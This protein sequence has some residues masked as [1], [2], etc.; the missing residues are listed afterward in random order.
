M[1]M[2]HRPWSRK[3]FFSKQSNGW[4]KYVIIIT[5][6]LEETSTWL[7]P[8]HKKD[9]VNAYWIIIVTFSRKLLSFYTW[10]ILMNNG[11][12]AYNNKRREHHVASCLN[13]FLVSYSLMVAWPDIK[14]SILP[15]YGLD[16][17]LIFFQL[18]LCVNPKLHP[19]C[20][21]FFY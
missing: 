7:P 18:G 14:A 15:A 12:H 9:E 19:L 8:F 3:P 21:E 6:L 4:G 16:H 5:R 20:F 11:T 13:W 2:D 17:W 1:I 10:L